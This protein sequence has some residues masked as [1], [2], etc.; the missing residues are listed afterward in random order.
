MV[1]LTG[2]TCN[3]IPC[4]SVTWPEFSDY[5]KRTYH[6]ISGAAMN[7]LAT[8][9]CEGFASVEAI[10]A[11]KIFAIKDSEV[12][13]SAKEKFEN[14]FTILGKADPMDCELQH[15]GSQGNG[16][17]QVCM[18]KIRV[19]SDV[20]DKPCVIYSVGSGGEFSFEEAMERLAPQ[21]EVHVFDCF[22][23]V[24]ELEHDKRIPKTKNTFF[25]DWCMGEG[26]GSR[27]EKWLSAAEIM[28]ELGHRRLDI[29]KMDIEGSEFSAMPGLLNS[30][31]G[32]ALPRLILMETH[33]FTVRP[34]SSD[35]RDFWFG[36]KKMGY[37]VAN[38][39]MN[40]WNNC[41]ADWTLVRVV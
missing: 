3:T 8:R 39:E 21:C 2:R 40:P 34:S 20:P 10:F 18:N 35:W 31:R 5:C 1:S 16:G 30:L 6:P 36:L 24:T 9:F 41:C 25:H 28:S 26:S 33:Y 12:M 23:K 37:R 11:R 27:N 22:R 29:L 17:Y 15:F 4:R 19:L 32:D 38:K 14:V 7:L 13:A